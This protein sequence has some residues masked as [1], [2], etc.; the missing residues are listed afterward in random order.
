[1]AALSQS[2]SLVILTAASRIDLVATSIRERLDDMA[3][4]P[5]TLVSWSSTVPSGSTVACTTFPF[6]DPTGSHA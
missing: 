3:D 1:V 6:L 2:A 5:L 4:R